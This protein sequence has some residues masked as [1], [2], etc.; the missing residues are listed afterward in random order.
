M[1]TLIMRML[2][3]LAVSTLSAGEKVTN[4][5]IDGC[6]ICQ[7]VAE[8]LIDFFSINGVDKILEE[9]LDKICE[10]LLNSIQAE[11]GLKA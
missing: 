7:V 10:A 11:V 8:A 1:K 3:Y 5:R 6:T 9:D 2:L 4:S